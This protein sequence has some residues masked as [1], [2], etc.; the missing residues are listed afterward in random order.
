VVLLLWTI[1]DQTGIATVIAALGA[2]AA[3]M[4]A[5]RKSLDLTAQDTIDELRG[6]LWARRG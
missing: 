1:L 5:I 4:V 3:T 2:L 6:D